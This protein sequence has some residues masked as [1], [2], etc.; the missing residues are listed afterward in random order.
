MPTIRISHL[1]MRLHV[2]LICVR[3]SYA[4]SAWACLRGV[5]YRL[6]MTASSL[7]P[8]AA[9]V[10]YDTMHSYPILEV[11]IPDA[12]RIN[13]TLKQSLGPT[14]LSIIFYTPHNTCVLQ[15]CKKIKLRC[16][17]CLRCLLFHFCGYGLSLQLKNYI[18][19]CS[20]AGLRYLHYRGADATALCCCD[21]AVSATITTASI[22]MRFK[23]CPFYLL[24]W[25][26]DITDSLRSVRPVA[27][28]CCR[29]IYGCSFAVAFVTHYSRY[30]VRTMLSSSVH[31]PGQ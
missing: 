25:Y 3:T 7:L 6:A 21:A 10:G 13:A 27:Y 11:H 17:S 23:H 9:L 26:Y 1:F 16:I 30:L 28:C 2:L 15:S 5:N 14:L 4:P 29:S 20:I 19:C 12:R 18:K 8:A 22:S 31:S 24:S